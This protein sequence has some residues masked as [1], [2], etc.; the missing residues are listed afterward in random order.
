MNEDHVNNENDNS[1]VDLVRVST[2]SNLNK[3]EPVE[4]KE[5][6]PQIAFRK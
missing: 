4:F 1:L 5:R 6:Y 3:I 2:N